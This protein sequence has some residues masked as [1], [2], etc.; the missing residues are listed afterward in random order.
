MDTAPE[1]G[2]ETEQDD[3]PEQFSQVTREAL[4]LSVAALCEALQRHARQVGGMR[5]GSSEFPALFEANQEVAR[6]VDA[7]N[8]RVSEHS[9]TLPVAQLDDDEDDDFE[10]DDLAEP[11]DGEVLSVV[12]RWDLRLADSGALLQA[13][14]AAHQRLRPEENDEDAVIAV[15]DFGQAMYS[16]LH[17]I[18]EPWYDLPGVE[19]ISGIRVFLRPDETPAPLP[20]DDDEITEPI[21][22]PAGEV[23]FAESWV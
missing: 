5:G 15:P 16:I 19:V 18:G 3:Y 23:L 9:G 2:P 12:S 8:E 1:T 13:G 4:E 14:R 20:D 22:Q 17:E 7:W 21:A 6:L 10:E 11:T